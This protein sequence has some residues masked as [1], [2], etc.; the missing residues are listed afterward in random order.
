MKNL[1]RWIPILLF[2]LSLLSGA[3]MARALHLPA[4]GEQILQGD[5]I[6]YQEIASSLL[7]GNG[8]SSNGAPTTMRPPLYPAFLAAVYATLGPQ[9]VFPLQAGLT[10]LL[11]VL[12]F[13]I[14][15]RLGGTGAGILAG[16]AIALY[17][18][19]QAASS[20]VVSEAHFT[21]LFI[22]AIAVMLTGKP[23]SGRKALLVGILLGL[24][25]LTRPTL[26]LLPVAFLLLLRVGVPW[27]F[28]S[29][30]ALSF[31]LTL[32][33]WIVRNYQVTGTLTPVASLGPYNMWQGTYHS[34]LVLGL[35]EALKQDPEF[36]ADLLRI[37]GTDNY[38]DYQA[39]P[40]FAK[41]ARERILA[42]P[43]RYAGYCLERTLRCWSAFP[44]T[45]QLADSHPW[46]FAGF[47]GLQLSL[48]GL[49]ILGLFRIPRLPRWI[50]GTTLGYAVVIHALPSLEARYLVPYYPL[51]LTLGAV[52]LSSW[53]ARLRFRQP[54]R[55]RPAA[56]V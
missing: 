50:L 14:G 21:L 32:A 27:R 20:M 16:L 31:G 15:R 40:R 54:L 43:L 34:P 9:A 47:T 48:L 30:V 55:E 7:A 22:G 49:A 33:P 36:Q 52:T 45:R 3:V 10:G 29:V 12:C 11:V 28:V 39:A 53:F 41:A 37:A 42:D 51:V 23:F 26:L 4:F 56:V 44:G 1:R 2:V 24:A 17:P 35:K 46:I 25:T 18:P 38:I 19:I 6:E 5:A 13:L 8:F